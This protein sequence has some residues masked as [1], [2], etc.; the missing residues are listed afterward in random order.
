MTNNAP[1]ASW[2]KKVAVD[3]A[4]RGEEKPYLQDL[5]DHFA[6][7]HM[8]KGEGLHL[9]QKRSQ[10]C[11]LSK[12][13]IHQEPV[14]LFDR[15][16]SIFLLNPKW[17]TAYSLS[18]RF[19]QHH[20]FLHLVIHVLRLHT[21]SCYWS[22]FFCWR[23]LSFASLGW[24]SMHCIHLYTYIYM[25]IHLYKSIYIYIHLCAAIICTQRT[26]K[27]KLKCK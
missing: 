24:I 15:F 25:Y 13:P 2:Q 21:C 17:L 27:R 9:N 12:G 20:F 23:C 19:C 26:R 6:S 16:Q 14:P 3:V 5:V 22:P 11:G 8:W 18:L 7:F 10:T 1:P 4:G